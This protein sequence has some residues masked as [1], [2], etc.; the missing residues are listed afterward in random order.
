MAR[1]KALSSGEETQPERK[2]TLSQNTDVAARTISDSGSTI[3]T[4]A[5][6]V[7]ATRIVGNA[8]KFEAWVINVAGVYSPSAGNVVSFE[9]DGVPIPGCANLPLTVVFIAIDDSQYRQASCTTSA[10]QFTTLGNK[11]ITAKYPGDIY[12]FGTVTNP[13]LTL[14]I[15]AA[16]VAP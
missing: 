10:T 16:P 7:S 1:V 6:S 3:P 2:A 15:T 4:A 8:V 5:V 14:A 13:A 9:A 12:N 11:V